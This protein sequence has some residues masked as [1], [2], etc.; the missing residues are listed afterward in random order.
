[1]YRGSFL[2]WIYYWY[3]RNPLSRAPQLLYWSKIMEIFLQ[4]E[5]HS[6]ARAL[7]ESSKEVCVTSVV[8][9]PLY[10]SHSR[11][12]NV[13]S[14]RVSCSRR[15]RNAYHFCF[16]WLDLTFIWWCQGWFKDSEMHLLSSHHSNKQ[17]A[18]L[19]LYQEDAS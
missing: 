16:S 15:Q 18:W 4:D 7:L 13:I 5:I 9:K 1:M 12:V 17:N 10:R 19:S 14:N 3:N 6:G 8:Q 11:G 2:M